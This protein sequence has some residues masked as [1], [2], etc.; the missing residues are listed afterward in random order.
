MTTTTPYLH[1]WEMGASGV[2][3][4]VVDM[5]CEACYRADVDRLDYR[6]GAVDGA[7]VRTTI[8]TERST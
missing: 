1:G 2:P 8:L 5:V 4:H 7:V 6:C 3:A